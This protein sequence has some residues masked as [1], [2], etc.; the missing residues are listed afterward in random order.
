MPAAI[1]VRADGDLVSFRP[2]YR[3][4]PDWRKRYVEAVSAGARI[5]KEAGLHR[6]PLDR[7]PGI[8]VRLRAARMPIQV[9]DAVAER[10]KAQEAAAWLDR[11][12]ADDRMRIID[13]DMRKNDKTFREYQRTG[14]RWLLSRSSGILGDDMGLGKSLQSLAAIPVDAAVL[15]VCPASVK[16]NW[17]REIKLWRSGLKTKVLSGMSS[18]RWPARGEVVI[19]NYDILPRAHHDACPRI[20]KEPEVKCAGCH[21]TVFRAHL[22]PPGCP[23]RAERKVWCAPG[24]AFHPECFDKLPPVPVGVVMI[25]DEAHLVKNARALRSEAVRAL[26]RAILGKDGGKAWYL[27]GTPVLN[28]PLELWDILESA[29][30]TGEAFGSPEGA[31]KTF[32]RAFG[33]TPKYVMRFDPKAGKEVARKSGWNWD[34]TPEAADRLSRVML[35]RLKSDVLKDLPAKQRRLFPVE[36]DDKTIAECD[37]LLEAAGGKLEGLGD[38]LALQKIRFE[39]VARV[40]SALAKAKIPAMLAM[41]EEHEEYGLP[42][43]V[44]SAHRPPVDLLAKREGWVAITGDT[45]AKE[46]D[47]IAAAFQEGKTPE[48]EPVRGIAGTIGAMGVGLTLTYA[49][50]MVFVDRMWTPSENAQAEDRISRLGQKN[51]TMITILV[52]QHMLDERVTEILEGKSEVIAATV[53]AAADR[54]VG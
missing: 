27:T 34:P 12:A 51:A 13:E 54:A 2:N 43:V 36:I 37:R 20:R 11:E 4:A 10:L 23:A 1:E 44:F 5:D 18:F 25:V 50:N 52:A 39:L 32:V 17:A 7:V 49:S 53:D 28:Q 31:F 16:G 19:V 29:E 22:P 3:M 47:R 24:A 45:P 40:R 33:G 42:L 41:V 30:L 35:R 48:G 38:L 46:R 8:L 26:S 15:V 14:V 6:A 9:D 21:P